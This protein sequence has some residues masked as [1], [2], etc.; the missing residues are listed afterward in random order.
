M[1][2]GPLV[3]QVLV[4]IS[5]L[6][7]EE[8]GFRKGQGRAGMASVQERSIWDSPHLKLLQLRRSTLSCELFCTPFQMV[9]T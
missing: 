1:S 3:N 9:P 7:K 4:D 5:R 6:G 2:H 8:H